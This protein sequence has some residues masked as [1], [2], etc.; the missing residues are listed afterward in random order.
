MSNMMSNET[1][2]AYRYDADLGLHCLLVLVLWRRCLVHIRFPP[3]HLCI[4][5]VAPEMERKLVGMPV[6]KQ[7]AC[8]FF[9]NNGQY[10]C[11]S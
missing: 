10:V 3:G 1:S 4:I 8:L 5:L 9:S 7:N 6:T 2:N 11:T